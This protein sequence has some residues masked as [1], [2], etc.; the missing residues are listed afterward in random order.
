MGILICVLTD[1]TPRSFGL[2]ALLIKH[3]ALKAEGLPADLAPQTAICTD[4]RD[5][6]TTLKRPHIRGQLYR[7]SFGS[8]VARGDKGKI[9]RIDGLAAFVWRVLLLLSFDGVLVFLEKGYHLS[10]KS[11]VIISFLID[12]ELSIVR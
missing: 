8:F 11:L 10:T 7:W 4:Q 9:D 2:A 1:D 5:P 6:L 3:G 12:T